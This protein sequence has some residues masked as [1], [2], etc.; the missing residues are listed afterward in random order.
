MPD[1][2]NILILMTDQHR[3]DSLGIAGHPVLMTP[4]ID[5]IA[6]EGARFTQATTVS[7]ICM[8]ARAAFIS[9]RYPH[10]TGMWMNSGRLPA[11]DPTCFHLLQAG[12]YHTA[13]VGKS[14]YY[15][16]KSGQGATLRPASPNHMR[17]HEGYMRARGFDTVH[18]TT[19]PRGVCWLDS[20]LTDRLR[21]K[22]LYESY[23]RDSEE[24][25]R[26]CLRPRCEHLTHASPL[27]TEEFPDSYVGRRAVEFVENYR[28]RKPL[29]LFVGFPG[30]HNPWDAPGDYAT[31]YDP[32]AMPGPVPRPEAE[33][34]VAR[35][36]ADLAPTP[37]LDPE[38]VGR[39]R[40]NYCGKISLIDHWVG[41][42][43]EAF[44][45][46]GW[47]E[48]LCIVFWSDHGE[49]A[50][51]HGRLYKCCYHESSVRVP[52]IVRCP[53]R[54]PAGTVS[55]AL[56]ETV[57]IPATILD[58]AGLEPGPRI[59]GRSLFPAAGG[60][61]AELRASQLSEIRHKGARNIMLRTRT[62]KLVLDGF[63]EVYALY[64]LATDPDE[65]NNLAGRPDAE[66]LSSELRAQLFR[67]LLAAQD[68]M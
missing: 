33:P 50:G 20:Y 2:P 25:T 7:P 55:D 62:H 26:A 27:P 44:E 17:L 60:K 42:I 32:R 3:A 4:N 63:G 21:E 28:E 34:P 64:D 24:R 8:P 61:G 19:G 51:D 43:L 6:A 54:I 67:R 18:E 36:R 59:L 39:V 12:G 13:H 58:A 9:G 66:G 15:A 53:G 52:L 56:A 23:V 37:G 49:M 57:D 29:C 14:H 45:A 68:C 48:R 65:Q 38:S 10:N 40:A 1:K 16:T 41:R 46:R 47:R 11:D 31:M 35:G 5:R 30:P 22:G